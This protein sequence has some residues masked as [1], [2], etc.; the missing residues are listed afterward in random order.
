MVN[1]QPSIG[2]IRHPAVSAPASAIVGFFLGVNANKLHQQ[3]AADSRTDGWPRRA[4]IRPGTRKVRRSAGQSS[5]QIGAHTLYFG[6]NKSETE[7][8]VENAM[9][10]FRSRLFP[11][12]AEYFPGSGQKIPGYVA[13]GIPPQAID[14]SDPFWG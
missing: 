5:F 14:E 8:F 4:G 10:I 7:P 1:C 3:R 6:S 11:G 13:T 2:I 12:Y 9:T